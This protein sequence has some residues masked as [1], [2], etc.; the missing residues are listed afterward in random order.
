MSHRSGRTMNS[1]LCMSFME[2]TNAR[3][4]FLAQV[5]DGDLL[6]RLQRSGL[7]GLDDTAFDDDV[8]VR[9]LFVLHH[10]CHRARPGDEPGL[11]RGRPPC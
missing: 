8:L 1:T 2:S 10:Q 9:R 5:P 3:P 11:A 6:P 7:D 4:P